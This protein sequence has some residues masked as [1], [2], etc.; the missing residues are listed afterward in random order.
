MGRLKIS[1]QAEAVRQLFMALEENA[2]R[3]KTCWFRASQL[4]R[5]KL[6]NQGHLSGNHKPG[7]VFEELATAGEH[8]IIVRHDDQQVKEIAEKRLCESIDA[9]FA[10][11]TKESAPNCP[12][13][14]CQYPFKLGHK[15]ECPFNALRSARGRG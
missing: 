8:C 15:L 6:A 10:A 12:F 4:S 7:C 11:M 3:I 14:I 9:L 1:P 13:P 5:L 2:K